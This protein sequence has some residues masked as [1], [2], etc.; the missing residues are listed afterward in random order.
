MNAVSGQEMK[1][2]KSRNAKWHDLIG[3][4]CEHED[5]ILFEDF[6]RAIFEQ[7]RRVPKYNGLR[8]LVSPKKTKKRK[9]L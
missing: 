6:C 3:D 4:L 1:V 8:A 9:R 2:L 5:I 7:P